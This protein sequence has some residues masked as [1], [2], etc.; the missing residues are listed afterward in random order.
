MYNVRFQPAILAAAILTAGPTLAQSQTL[1]PTN[2]SV[3]EIYV[4]GEQG[5][6]DTATKLEL[7]VFET[8]QT[9]TAISRAQMDDF[10]LNSVSELLNY[11]PGVTVEEIETNRTYYTARG[12]DIVNFQYDGVGIPF[13]S[14]LNL[15]QQDTAI[16]EK[17]E[18]VKGAAGLITGLANPSA[19]INYVRKRPTEVFD[20]STSVGYGQWQQA[21]IDTDIS[22][23]VASAARARLVLA[24][25][26]GDN[27]LDRNSNTT[28]LAYGV[29]EFDVTDSILL[30]LGH[31]YNQHE[32]EGVLWGALPLTYAD[33]S[34]TDFRVSTSNAPDWTFANTTQNQTF[35]EIKQELGQNWSLN[36]IVTRNTS[37]YE[38]AL[39]Y[40]YGSLDRDTGTGLLGYASAYERE[41]EQTNLDL[42]AS[43]SFTLG[44]REHQLVAGLNYSDTTL[45]EASR[46]DYTN[47][48]PVLGADWAAGNSARPSFT[49]YDPATSST[50]LDLEQKAVY[51]ATRWS[52]MDNVSLLLG[53]R[54]TELDQ[55]GVSYGGASQADAQE[56]VPYVGLTY[57][58]IDNLMLYASYSEVFKQQTWVNADLQPLGATLGDSKEIGVKQSI[59]NSRA[60]VTLAFF[61][62][63]QDNFG[64]FI[65]RNDLGIAI[66]Q[67]VSLQSQGVELE[68]SGEVL[69][70]LNVA[71]GVTKLDIENQQGDDIRP[72]IPRKTFK[73]S[74]SYTIPNFDK[75]SLGGVIKWQDEINTDGDLVSEGAYTLLDL[76]LNYQVLD[77]LGISFNI[78]NLTDKKY[79]NSLYWTQG[80]YG[81]PRHTSATVRWN[82]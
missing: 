74:A 80:F 69:P 8:P 18:V 77:N 12:F 22:G 63:S 47:G 52:L 10:A 7:T 58:V 79:I 54:N 4:Y 53:A 15:G 17:V 9:I 49:D 14:G 73:A 6:T 50:D 40:V 11:V 3:E 67:G 45:N 64:T 46:Y 5:T 23:A 70:G 28:S 2:T 82:F 21:R 39:F 24:Y 76:A 26:D 43:G 13:I 48:F 42:Y 35:V 36:G 27:Y 65:G 16:Y 59:N 32:S 55:Q 38:S 72:F 30:T 51:L 34:A 68:V 20:M 78:E 1:A 81:A 75:L 19:T 33:G 61:E 66:Y 56:T 29:W 60:T 62:S 31:S 37:D 71:A 41:E 25:D 44:G 57:E